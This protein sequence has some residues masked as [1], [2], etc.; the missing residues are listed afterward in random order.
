MVYRLHVHLVFTPK[1]RRA[2]MTPRV[3]ALLQTTF[4][5]VCQRFGATLEEFNTDH[6]HAHLLVTYPP[7]IS[8]SRLV[9][10]LKTNSS[11]QI[12]QQHWP[13]IT[14][15]LWGPNFWSPSYAAI[16]CGGAP[17]DLIAQYITNQQHPNRT[18]G[19]PPKPPRR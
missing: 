15:A 2:I 10:A 14:H 12:R 13:E 16:S 19:R 6:D 1:Y 9:G 7:K 3:T 11:H 17:L 8:L 4:T 18:K 5:E